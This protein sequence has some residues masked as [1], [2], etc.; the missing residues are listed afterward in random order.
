MTEELTNILTFFTP[1]RR[2][3]LSVKQLER[4]AGLPAG[5]LNH[6]IGR[7]R[8]LSG[9]HLDKLVPILVEFGYKPVTPQIL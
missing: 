5:T 2:R 3:C 8:M 6:F 4:E 7:R 9:E 1:L